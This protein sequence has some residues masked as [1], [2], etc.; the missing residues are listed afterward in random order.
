MAGMLDVAISDREAVATARHGSS[1]KEG[2]RQGGVEVQLS[3]D[4]E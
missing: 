3:D 1:G 2:D 4:G